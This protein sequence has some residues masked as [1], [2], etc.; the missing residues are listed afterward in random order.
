MQKYRYQEIVDRI[1]ALIQ[2][3]ELKTGDK[4]PPER[5]LAETFSVSRNCVREAIRAL[6]EKGILESRMG[7]GTYVRSSDADEIKTTLAKAIEAQKARIQEIFELRMLLEP[8]IASLAA[9]RIKPESLDRLKAI[10][11]DQGRAAKDGESEAHL[12]AL[13]HQT[14][15]E[16]AGNSVVLTVMKTISTLLQD[17]RSEFM[18]PLRRKDVSVDGHLRII[19]AL[20]RKNPLGA[21]SAMND[22]IRDMKIITFQQDGDE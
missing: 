20:E 18:R 16:T 7:N 9:K 17:T 10:V 21:F 4:I 8:Q 13:F 19:E 14:L 11:L 2:S 12:D 1:E 3:G 5:S 6:A 15:A 22:H